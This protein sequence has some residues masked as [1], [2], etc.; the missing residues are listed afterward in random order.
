MTLPDRWSGKGETGPVSGPVV[1]GRAGRSML[2]DTYES[3]MVGDV[4]D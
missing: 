4:D 3:D 2:D 1:S